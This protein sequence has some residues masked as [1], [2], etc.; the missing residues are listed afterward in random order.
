MIST[1][2]IPLT[3]SEPSKLPKADLQPSKNKINQKFSI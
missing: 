3:N 1:N 2:D